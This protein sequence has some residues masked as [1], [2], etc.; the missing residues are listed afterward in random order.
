MKG[1]ALF[2]ALLLGVLLL[3]AGC[4]P[5]GQ[6]KI[7][8]A[9]N[10]GQVALEV[11]QTLVLSLESNPTTGYGWQIAELDEALLKETDHQ[12]KADWP[13]LI[14]SGGKEVW[15]FQAQSSGSTT[16]RLE[17]RRPWEKDVEPIQTFSVQVVVR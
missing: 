16:L 4:G 7:G 15:R 3:A 9:D 6:V 17:Y 8:E 5:R 1:R 12:Y 13:V 11:G 2:P 10:G 14:G